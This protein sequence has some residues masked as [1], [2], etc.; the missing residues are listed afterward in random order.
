MEAVKYAI[1]SFFFP[2]ATVDNT[3]G[4]Y[5]SLLAFR[6][7]CASRGSFQREQLNIDVSVLHGCYAFLLLC[8]ISVCHSLTTPLQCT[9]KNSK[10]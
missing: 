9:A 2:E 3:L 10:C 8:Y 4:A 6:D 7:M 5:F 1:W